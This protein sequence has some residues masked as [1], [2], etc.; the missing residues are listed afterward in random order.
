M[1]PFPKKKTK[2]N[3][4]HNW[5]PIRMECLSNPFDCCHMDSYGI[6]LHGSSSL[7]SFS[8]YASH[9]NCSPKGAIVHFHDC[10]RECIPCMIL[11]I[12]IL[13]YSANGCIPLPCSATPRRKK[14]TKNTHKSR[15]P[16]RLPPWAHPPAPH[17]NPRI[18][19]LE[20][21]PPES[22]P[23]LPRV[24]STGPRRF[25]TNIVSGQGHKQV[26]VSEN[27][28]NNFDMTTH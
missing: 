14:E 18:E 20:Q 17:C 12:Y 21:P 13:F 3:F 4:A 28:D 10:F 6:N 11:L 19:P 26:S 8:I 1:N 2:K 24:F 16:R 27:L 5:F 23:R 9:R 25:R 15:G 7:S 22:A